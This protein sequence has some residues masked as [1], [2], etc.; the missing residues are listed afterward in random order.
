MRILFFIAAFIG[1]LSLTLLPA[2][3]AAPTKFTDTRTYA[4]VVAGVKKPLPP[5]PVKPSGTSKKST[6]S[7]LS[8]SKPIKQTNPGASVKTEK[9]ASTASQDSKTNTFSDKV[10]KFPL[11]QTNIGAR[12]TVR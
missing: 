9:P 4:Q 6:V 11:V 2:A 8:D 5:T 7:D 10:R 1:L 12:L 3:N